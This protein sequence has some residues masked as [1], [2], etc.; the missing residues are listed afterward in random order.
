[1][2]QSGGH[3]LPAGQ[4]LS[5][6]PED[7]TAWEGAEPEAGRRCP[8]QEGGE[9]TPVPLG[10]NHRLIVREKLLNVWGPAG[11]ALEESITW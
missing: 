1:M 9:R 3:L 8:S 2:G 7:G 11:G 6:D 4:G 10:S 5:S